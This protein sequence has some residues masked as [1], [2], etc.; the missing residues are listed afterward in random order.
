VIR[1]STVPWDAGGYEADASRAELGAVVF[2]VDTFAK[3]IFSGNGQADEMRTITR[4]W[5]SFPR[6]CTSSMVIPNE[7]AVS[8]GP[9]RNRGDPRAMLPLDNSTSRFLAESLNSR[10][11]D[12]HFETRSLDPLDGMR[13][14]S[15]G[16]YRA[17]ET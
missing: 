17:A 11:R 7:P 16:F 3:N 12:A 13:Q 1:M 4:Q 2:A 8:S 10:R 5:L 15:G 14:C 6:S 9:S